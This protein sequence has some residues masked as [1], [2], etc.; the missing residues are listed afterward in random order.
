MDSYITR[1]RS[2]WLVLHP[3][4]F[5]WVD[6]T[7]PTYTNWLTDEPDNAFGHEDCGAMRGGEEFKAGW[8]DNNCDAN[9]NYI[10]EKNSGTHNCP[11]GW[12]THGDYCYQLNAHPVQRWMNILNYFQAAKWREAI[13]FI[14][15]FHARFPSHNQRFPGLLRI[16]WFLCK[17]PDIR[18]DLKNFKNFSVTK[19]SRI[20]CNKILKYPSTCTFCD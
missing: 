4:T 11:G 16:N 2:P 9:N 3:G 19:F 20:L 12:I 7:T 5:V 17:H 15:R 8:N 14:L 6:E 18:E 10:C 1:Y 13:F